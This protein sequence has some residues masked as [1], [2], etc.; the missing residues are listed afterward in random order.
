[1]A[2]KHTNF[3]TIY[4][5]SWQSGLYIYFSAFVG[6][7]FRRFSPGIPILVW[8]SRMIRELASRV[9]QL[10]LDAS[11]ILTHDIYLRVFI[12]II[13]A[14]MAHEAWILQCHLGTFL[15]SFLSTLLLSSL[16][17]ILVFLNLPSFLYHSLS[18][19]LFYIGKSALFKELFSSNYHCHNLSQVS[20]CRQPRELLALQHALHMI[21]LTRNT[22]IIS[23]LSSQELLLPS[24]SVSL[25]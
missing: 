14:T 20:I 1:M 6:L 23:L 13:A 8:S 11:G 15:F 2:T 18:K 25:P 5:F 19:P 4:A 12:R 21:H 24:S 3:W 7:L 9:L 10:A 17:H 16:Y 22:T